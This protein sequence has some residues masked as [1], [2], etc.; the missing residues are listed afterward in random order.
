MATSKVTDPIELILADHEK[1]RGLFDEFERSNN[2]RSKARI[3]REI[4]LELDVHAGIEEEIY[5]PAVEEA[6]DDADRETITEA[7]EE[8]HVVHVLI[9]EIR[10]MSVDDDHFDAKMTVLMENVRH[11]MEEEEQEMLP[12]SR[13]VI[14]DAERESLGEQMWER[15][16][17]LTKELK[18]SST[19]A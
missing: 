6:L 3:A 14:D 8:H 10:D 12:K 1:M 2:K 19:A 11:H 17:A 4:V 16:R 13:E 15:K 18:A 7:E 9:A 5:Y